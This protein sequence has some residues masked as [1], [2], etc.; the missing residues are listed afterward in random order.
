MRNLLVLAASCLLSGALL[1]SPVAQAQDGALKTGLA[2]RQALAAPAGISWKGAPLR[3]ALARL[4][5]AHGISIVLDRRIDPEQSIEFNAGEADLEE[6]LRRLASKLK[7]GVSIF[8]STVYIGPA[9]VTQRL[10]TLAAI[11]AERKKLA[12]LPELTTQELQTPRELLEAWSKTTGVTL[13]GVDQLPHD[14]WPAITFPA[15]SPAAR[16]SLLLAGFDSAI[17]MS[18]DGKQARIIPLPERVTMQKQFAGG[19]NPDN[20]AAQMREKFPAAEIDIVGKQLRV[21]G[22]FEDID[23]IGRV[24]SGE[25]VTRKEVRAGEQ[26]FTLKVEN[27][28]VG[29]VAR[30][31]AGKLKMEVTFATG[32]E[33]QLKQLISF[34]VDKATLEE[35][36][37][38]MLA[39]AGL[40]FEI[41]ENTIQVKG[42]G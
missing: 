6:A 23:A 3:P 14:L 20:R 35:L 41:D 36:L 12:G 34:E 9:Q 2:F 1:F 15:Q 30:A 4:S 31:L 11:G 29:A 8:D 38:K 42:K 13:A 7:A 10:A 37:S 39:P 27:Q 18:S 5:A 26:R 28:P 22:S 33:E 25:K 17:E 19:T 40:D 32:T 16:A 24:L 21:T